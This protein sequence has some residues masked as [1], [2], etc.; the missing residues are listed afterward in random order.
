MTPLFPTLLGPD[1]WQALP[2]PVQRMHGSPV[3]VVAEGEA[4]IEGASHLVARLL[5]RL[6]GLPEPAPRQKLRVVI[7]PDGMQ[8]TWA[9]HFVSRRMQSVLSRRVGS[10]LLYECLGPTTLGFVLRRD[11]DAIDWSLQH[12]W[13]FGIPLPRVCF[14][15]ILSRSGC[16][17]GRYA[18]TVDTRLPLIGQ[19]V[20]YR[21]WLEIV[22][23]A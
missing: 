3:R 1:A 15:S 23:D 19:L 14:G 13:A 20:A 11:G 18:F 4:D 21:G 7:T 12:V 17:D 22:P 16:A 6:L 2:A 5:R 10:G 8:E 9:R